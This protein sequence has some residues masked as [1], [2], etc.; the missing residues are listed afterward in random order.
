MNMREVVHRLVE[1]L[2]A[3]DEQILSVNERQQLRPGSDKR[4]QRDG[5]SPS[6]S[7]SATGRSR[8]PT[9]AAS[10]AAKEVLPVPGEP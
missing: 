3:A 9:R 6:A 1:G 8:A 5:S 2:A 10:V 7:A 4:M